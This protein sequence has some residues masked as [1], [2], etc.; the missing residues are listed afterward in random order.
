MHH[1]E[2]ELYDEET[3]RYLTG[4]KAC[5]GAC[6][7]QTES[8]GTGPASRKRCLALMRETCPMGENNFYVE[9]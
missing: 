8:F 4:V 2:T 7:N 3:G 6:G 9:E 5:C 1:G